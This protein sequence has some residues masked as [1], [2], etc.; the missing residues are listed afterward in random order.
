[1]ENHI[2][3]FTGMDEM[4]RFFALKL[5]AH[6]RE[7]P[8]GRHFSLALSGGKTPQKVFEYL[9]SNFR[10]VIDWKK[11]LVFWSDERCVPPESDESNFLMAEK[12]LLDHVPIPAGNIFRIKGEADPM[13]EAAR[14]EHLV[15]QRLS[16]N[17]ETPQFDFMMLGL[18]EDGH[19]ASIF[20]EN[21]HL[22]QSERLFEMSENPH[23][24]QKRI[25][26]TG[27][28]IN[29]SKCI[30]LMVSGFQKAGIVSRILNKEK[31]WE[32]LPASLV[33]PACGDQFW[34]LDE[35]A[36]SKLSPGTLTGL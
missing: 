29:H 35:A 30:I 9:A 11:I 27:K 28:M 10:E 20:P 3:T 1:M 33:C 25:T 23:S 2:V 8:K 12:T 34:L 17:M 14:Y 26:A 36:A 21:I 4:A 32:Q 15:R 6:M 18:G 13:A 16:D 24:H 22:F 19:T 7:L 31:G 5:V